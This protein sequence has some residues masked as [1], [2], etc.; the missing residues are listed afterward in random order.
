MGGIGLLHG[1][2]TGEHTKWEGTHLDYREVS[3]LNSPKFPQKGVEKKRGEKRAYNVRPGKVTVLTT[4][5]KDPK[6]KHEWMYKKI[7]EVWISMTGDIFIILKFK[8]TVNDIPFAYNPE[9]FGKSG[10]LYSQVHITAV[11]KSTKK[12]NKDD[13]GTSGKDEDPT[14]TLVKEI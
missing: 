3:I 12:E 2:I 1:E 5:S 7:H 4:L 13:F 14:F 6:E 9:K 10:T 8:D 11:Q